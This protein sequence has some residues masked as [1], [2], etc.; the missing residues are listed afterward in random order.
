MTLA[1]LGQSALD[2]LE[3]PQIPRP[4][5][6]IAPVGVG[7]DLVFLPPDQPK[8]V[9]LDAKWLEDPHPLFMYQQRLA[10]WLQTKGH[11]LKSPSFYP[12]ITIARMPFKKEQWQE[13]FHPIP[14]FLSAVHL[15]ESLKDLEYRVLWSHPLKKPFI[16]L[17][18]T[19]DLA[20]EICG[21]SLADLS[22]HAQL[23][24]FFTFPPLIEYYT[25]IAAHSLEA[26]II[27]LNQ[28]IAK[29][30][31]ECGCPFKAVSFHGKMQERG[32]L[33]YWEMIVDV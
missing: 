24:L 10:E 3:F 19:A 33:Y 27:V 4:H 7:S 13:A 26:L 16:E 25:L 17:E 1:F 21:T 20:F 2:F 11:T 32:H 29:C 5:F 15:Y 28:M 9:A 6:S 14:F 8:V 30:D 22:I 12:H 18:H 23:A 31:S